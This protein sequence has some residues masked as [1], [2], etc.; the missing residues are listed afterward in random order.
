M[1]TNFAKLTYQKFTPGFIIKNSSIFFWSWIFRANCKTYF[2][3]HRQTLIWQRS[4]G[5]SS[6]FVCFFVC[7]FK[8]N[9]FSLTVKLGTKKKE[10]YC[11]KNYFEN[12]ERK[13]NTPAILCC[14]IHMFVSLHMLLSTR[15]ADLHQE[16]FAMHSPHLMI[17]YCTIIRFLFLKNQVLRKCT[18]IHCFSLTIS[19]FSLIDCLA[20]QNT[21]CLWS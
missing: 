18:T 4:S 20:I 15:M 9:R 13:K 14:F 19:L 3:Y 6:F 7:F 21:S 16:D 8:Q 12:L 1:N 2:W 10:L 11:K 17:F 5:L